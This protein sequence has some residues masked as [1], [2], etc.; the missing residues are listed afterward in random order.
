MEYNGNLQHVFSIKNVLRFGDYQPKVTWA[1]K[2][3]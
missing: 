2:E 1:S 3:Y